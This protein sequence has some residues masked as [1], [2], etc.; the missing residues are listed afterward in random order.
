[1]P[2]FIWFSI[3][4]FESHSL[5]C[6][7]IA[8]TKSEAIDRIVAEFP[9]AAWSSDI[10]QDELRELL[11]EE[12]PVVLETAGNEYVISEDFR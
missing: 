11:E 8:A 3:K 6:A 7:A 4:R 12:E 1:M 9:S 10:D 2:T 5:S